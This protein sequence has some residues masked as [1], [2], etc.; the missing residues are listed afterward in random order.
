MSYIKGNYRSSIYSNNGYIIGLFKLKETD[1]EE[2]VDYINKTITFTGYFDSLN[3]DENYIF[4]GEISNH[5]KYGLQYKVSSY[6]RIKP[7]DIDGIIQ[8]LS[9]DLF[10]GIGTSLASKIVKTLGENTLNIILE[11]KA[12]LYAVPKLSEKK[13]D[14]IYDTLLKY[15]ESHK[16]IVYLTELGFS[17]REALSIYN[18]YKDKTINQIEYNIYDVIDNV[19]GI[20]FVKIDTIAKKMDIDLYDE[21][22]IKSC[23]YYVMNT[24]I[25]NNGDTYL[26][27]EE[28][29]N[30]TYKYLNYELSDID[31]YLSEIEYEG[32]IVIL[33]NKY[34]IKDMYSAELNIATKLKILLNKKP[35]KYKNLDNYISLLEKDNN[36]I[37]NDEQKEAIKSSLENNVTIITGGPG[38]GKTTII[39][40][41]VDLYISINDLRTDQDKEEIKLLAPTGRASKRLAE[42]TLL[43]SSTIHRFLK[44]DKDT[45]SFG[46]NE[47]NK[48]YSKLIIVDEVSM[49]DTLLLDSLFKGLTN[50]IKLVLVGD[51]N[52]L[53]SVGPGLVLK[54]LIDSEMIK[55][56]KL[57]KLYRQKENSY[58][59]YLA[60]EI[61][62][63]NLS[64]FLTTRDDYTFLKCSYN[65]IRTTLIDICSKLIEKKYSY[66]RVQIMAPLYASINGIDNLNKIL[67]NVFNPKDESK[68]ELAVGDVIFRENDKI[69][70]LVNMPDK[71]VYNGDIGIIDRIIPSNMSDSKKNEIVVNFDGNYVTYLPKDFSSIKHGYVISIHKSQGS[72]FELVII[73]ICESYKRMLYRKLIYTGI[74]RAKSKLILLGDSDS[75]VYAV[76]NNN[77][78]LRKTTLIE[79]LK[80]VS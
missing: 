36:I 26:N 66:K 77:E 69:L 6:D 46:I 16:T 37:Y 13:I 72:E 41:I 61:K 29:E 60:K 20:D 25:F 56:I 64:D 30:Y 48:D 8:F 10:K 15:E 79:K 7:S 40:A 35:N 70:Q 3:Q 28:I 73:P 17:M 47:Y 1:E 22:R 45:N 53:P 11:D 2:L 14:I 78:I 58:I 52:Q 75:F 57:E 59:P 44:W 9:S 67:Q 12:N 63:N 80:N 4:N 32:K 24:L 65:N 19:E 51:Y 71:N 18:K 23:I 68:K 5:P 42:S 74:T 34:Y 27:K 31:K 43:K 49:V 50:N 54:D 76:S 33:D 21:S 38:V 62:E 39:K 55:T